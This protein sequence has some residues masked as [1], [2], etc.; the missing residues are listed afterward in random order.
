[1][2]AR[3]SIP[4]QVLLGPGAVRE[5]PDLVRAMGRRRPLIV[6]DAG[7]VKAG[8]AERVAGSLRDAGLSRKAMEDGCHRT[9]PRP[10]RREDMEELY[11]RAL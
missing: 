6:T 10:C 2:I 8:L 11:R 4:T 7:V 5:I 1:M 3:F 9:N